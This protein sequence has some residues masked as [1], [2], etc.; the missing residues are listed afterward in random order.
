MGFD[1]IGW[2]VNSIDKK[3][4]NAVNAV[5]GALGTGINLLSGDLDGAKKESEN[6][7]KAAG[8]IIKSE[9]TGVLL[10]G[11]ESDVEPE[12]DGCDNENK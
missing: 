3:I 5:D 12:V 7:I 11:I 1:P 4:E 9:I 6:A 10:D 8:K 2:I